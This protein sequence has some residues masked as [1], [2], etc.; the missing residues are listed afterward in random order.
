[1]QLGLTGGI[2]SGK[3]TV[4]V[5]LVECGA[6][7]IDA[8][9]IARELTAKGG[10]AIP[11]VRDEMGTEFIGPDGALDRDIMRQRVFAEP[12]LRTQLEGIVHP[13]VRQSMAGRAAEAMQNGVRLIV[14]DIPLLVESGRWR[15]GL[16]RILV[17]DCDSKTQV[18]RVM[19]RSGLSQQAV[20][21]IIA[22]QA[23]RLSRLACAD[24]VLYNQ[25]MNLADLALTTRQIA[26]L[27]GL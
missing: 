1:M 12:Q 9:A 22:T 4:A 20:E 27:F 19:L 15:Q 7:L 13:L 14:F 26:R 16:D 18:Q 8:D 6:T 5:Q 24:L 25:D 21:A 2:G 11:R 10:A 17:V 3:S 23:T